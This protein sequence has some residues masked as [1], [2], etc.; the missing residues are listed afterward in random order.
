VAV[1]LDHRGTSLSFCPLRRDREGLP[2]TV[3]CLISNAVGPKTS[4]LVVTIS[5]FKVKNSSVEF[6][7]GVVEK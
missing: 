3:D 5:Q 6:H 1:S 4:E 2:L 7:L